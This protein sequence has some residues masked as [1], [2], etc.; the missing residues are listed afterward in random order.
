MKGGVKM[1]RRLANVFKVL[2]GDCIVLTVEADTLI[3]DAGT[4]TRDQ[5]KDVA[6]M[7]FR[8]VYSLA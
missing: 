8:T 7:F 4:Q 5:L 1:L 3:V 2:R 6:S